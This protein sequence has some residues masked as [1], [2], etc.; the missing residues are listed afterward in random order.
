MKTVEQ[1]GSPF[2]IS[3]ASFLFRAIA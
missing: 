1:K 3:P 2:V